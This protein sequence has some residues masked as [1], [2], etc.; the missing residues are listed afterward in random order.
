MR[1][2]TPH[3]GHAAHMSNNSPTSSRTIANR[4]GVYRIVS[5]R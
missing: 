4:C 2:T 3:G 5:V 1:H